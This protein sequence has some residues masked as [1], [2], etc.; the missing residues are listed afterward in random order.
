MRNILA[1]YIV[2][3]TVLLSSFLTMSEIRADPGDDLRKKLNAVKA[4]IDRE[5]DDAYKV[6]EAHLDSLTPQMRACLAKQGGHKE[7]KFHIRFDSMGNM[8]ID[9]KGQFSSCM[10][11]AIGK[12]RFDIHLSCLLKQYVKMSY[13]LARIHKK[14][15]GT[16]L[17]CIAC[18]ALLVNGEMTVSYAGD[19][20]KVSHDQRIG[21][22]PVCPKVN[23]ENPD[24][25][26]EKIDYEFV[27]GEPQKRK[28]VVLCDGV[29]DVNDGIGLVASRVMVCAAHEAHMVL[30]LLAGE[31]QAEE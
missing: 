3:S 10:A 15:Y 14:K 25:D 13:D 2:A 12:Q 29:S 20:M 31:E 1:K 8:V 16:G 5:V 21:S 9:K 7:G 27:W 17:Q 18:P 4:Q 23:C 28:D 24:K 19:A 30:R 6:I 11:E 22:F 26:A